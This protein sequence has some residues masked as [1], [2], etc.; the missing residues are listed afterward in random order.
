MVRFRDG[1]PRLQG[2][3]CL[4]RAEKRSSGCSPLWC[5]SYAQLAEVGDNG[6][7]HRD[8]GFYQCEY[9]I[10]QVVGHRGL[11]RGFVLGYL[12]LFCFVM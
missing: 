7:I 1:E 6:H 9:T 11:E 5:V 4:R 2:R 3:N 12:E 8:G 10:S